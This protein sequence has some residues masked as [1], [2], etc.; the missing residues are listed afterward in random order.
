MTESVPGKDHRRRKQPHKH[1]CFR[2]HHRNRAGRR[3]ARTDQRRS[4]LPHRCLQQGCRIRHQ[5]SLLYGARFYYYKCYFFPATIAQ[6]DFFYYNFHPSGR[7]VVTF[8]QSLN[9][10]GRL[11]SSGLILSFYYYYLFYSDFTQKI[12]DERRKALAE[13]PELV[14]RKSFIVGFLLFLFKTNDHVLGYRSHD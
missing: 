1:V 9:G 11:P 6:N 14:Q 10:N 4:P 8:I 3:G 2:R 7:E 12:I 5:S 13:N